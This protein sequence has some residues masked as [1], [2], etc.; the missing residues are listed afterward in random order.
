MNIKD[1]ISLIKQGEKIDVELKLSEKGINKDIYDTVCSF[2]NRDGGH[3]IL[4]VEDGTKEIRGVDT[5]IVDKMLKDFT[6]AINNPLKL[7]PPIYL[8]PEVYDIDGKKIIYISNQIL[9]LLILT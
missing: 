6:T 4:G 7:N 2:N 3:I 8:T 1:I 9:Y 5:Q